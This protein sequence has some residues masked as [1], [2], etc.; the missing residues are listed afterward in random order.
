M[1]TSSINIHRLDNGM[2][3]IAEPIPWLETASFSFA[4]PAGCQF[5][6][7]DRL[8][9]ANF[10]CEM[11]QRGCGSLNSR[12]FI[13][14]LESL[15]V[16]YSSSASIYHTYFSGALPS[17]QLAPTLDLYSDV[18][19][20]PHIPEQQLE[21]ARMV[22][23]QE[24]RAVEDDLAQKVM[25]QLRKRQYGDPLG[26][27]S[28]GEFETVQA[29]THDDIVQF[30]QKYYQPNGL[31]LSVAGK[32]DWN[33]LVEQVESLFGDWKAE[34]IDQQESSQQETGSQHIQFDSQ[35]THIG[36]AYPSLAYSD[37]NYFVARGAVGVLS[38]GM[39]SR[40]FSEIR[41]KRGLCYSVYSSLH[42]LRD[43]GAI[44]SYVGTGADRAQQSLDLLIEELRKLQLGITEAELGRLKVQVRSSLVMQQES[45]RSRAASISSDLFH[46]GRARTLD[47]INQLINDLT[48]E[49]INDYLATH[50][51][52]K[53][54]LVTLGP[55]PLEFRDA[56]SA[57][58][59]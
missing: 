9:L 49:R 38:D 6:P 46:L 59:T 7:T 1:Q 42:S 28:Q 4:V 29:I 16:D 55:N 56:V 33:S 50:P 52:E 45:S 57:T 22:C 2:T 27:S 54:N 14:R 10:A 32:V 51:P 40:L 35:Q 48:V 58:T 8:G 12:E 41:E 47:E 15:G 24:I 44:V 34:Q 21:D 17:R 20:N 43:R 23:Y 25:L 3:L 37:E 30:Y 19:R 36:L 5:D 31:I 39:S 26:R 13:E 18:L 53:F 11:V